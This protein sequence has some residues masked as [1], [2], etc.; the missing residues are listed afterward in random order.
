M[1]WN[2]ISQW[3]WW[4]FLRNDRP[5]NCAN[6]SPAKVSYKLRVGFEPVQNLK[7]DFAEWKG[8]A[9]LAK[10]YP[11]ANYFYLISGELTKIEECMTSF[12]K[13]AGKN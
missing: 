6:F 8:Q 4:K 9:L 2:K 10:P 3:W 1:D 5:F 7:S 12:S 11:D 13:I